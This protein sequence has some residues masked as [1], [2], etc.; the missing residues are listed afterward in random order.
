MTRKTC[1][2][3]L[4]YFIQ[5]ANNWGKLDY[6]GTA[7]VFL[8]FG[9]V[10]GRANEHGFQRTDLKEFVSALQDLTESDRTAFV[11]MADSAN[12]FIRGRSQVLR[13]RLP[14]YHGGGHRFERCAKLLWC[15]EGAQ[16][17]CGIAS[18]EISKC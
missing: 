13:R 10:G 15:A 14:P 4:S 8:R 18:D 6:R 11:R 9:A 5:F 16:T 3:T 2:R 12:S 7:T 17:D 1:A